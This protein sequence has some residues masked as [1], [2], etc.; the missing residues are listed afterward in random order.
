MLVI[1]TNVFL[2]P[3]MLTQNYQTYIPVR[4]VHV[5]SCPL[6]L[7]IYMLNSEILS[8]EDYEKSLL[9]IALFYKALQASHAF[10]NIRWQFE[11]F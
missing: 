7:S 8:N 4:Y 1:F 9:A 6:D 5:L 3:V 11:F 10:L 2:L